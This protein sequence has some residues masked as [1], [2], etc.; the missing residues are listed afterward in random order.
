MMP[1]TRFYSYLYSAN[2]NGKNSQSLVDLN[3]DPRT[4]LTNI[5]PNSFTVSKQNLYAVLPLAWCSSC[6]QDSVWKFP[7]TSIRYDL[8]KMFEVHSAGVIGIAANYKMKDQFLGIAD[9]NHD[10]YETDDSFKNDLS[11]RLTSRS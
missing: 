3:A 8:S 1:E 10:F 2:L 11:Y 7:K 4:V 6:T 9:C 5:H